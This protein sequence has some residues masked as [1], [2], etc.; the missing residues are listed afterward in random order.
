MNYSKKIDKKWQNIWEE[1]EINKFNFKNIKKKLYCLEMFAY[2]SGKTL[3]LGHWFNFALTDSWARMKKMQGYEVF[4]PMGFDA[5]GLPAENFAI[6]TGIHPQDST[7]ENIKIMKEQLKEM[8]AMFESGSNNVAT[9]EPEYYRWTQWLFLQ[10]YDKKL[11][12]R[13]KAPVNWCENCKTVLANEQ[14]VD[15]MCERC[16]CEIVKK[17]LT[18]WF[19]KITDYAEELLEGLDNLDWPEKTKKN[20]KNWIGKSTG[21]EITLKI[22]KK[23]LYI[24]IFT[25]RIDTLMGVSYC[26]IAPEH[27]LVAK[28]TTTE[29]QNSVNNYIEIALTKGE[30][31][32]IADNG[33]KTGVFTGSYAIHPI[34]KKLIPIWV[35]DYVLEN[36]G[37]GC[38]M[39]VPAHDERD[40]NFAQKYHLP[41]IQVIREIKNQKLPYLSK[42]GVL[43][44]STQTLNGLSVEESVKKIEKI[45]GENV[46]PKINYKLRD[47]LV[48][49]QRY[50]GAPIPVIYCPKCGVVPVSEEDLP[51]LLPYDVEFSPRGESP[52]KNH[53]SFINTK[54]HVCGSEA[55]RDPDTLD[56]FVCS[57]WYFLRYPDFNNSKEIFNTDLINKILPVDKYV[58][59]PEHAIMHLL[60]ARFVT[61][62]LR[63]IGKIDFSE[64]FLSLVHQGLILG[65]DGTKMSKSKGNTISPDGYVKEYGSDVFRLHLMFAFSYADGGSW[66]N[67]GMKAILRFVSRVEN[68]VENIV[69][70]DSISSNLINNMDIMDDSNEDLYHKIHT[71]IKGVT[72]DADKFQFNTV[73]AK[74]M[75]LLNEI[76]NYEKFDNKNEN[77]YAQAVMILIRLLA[78]FAPHFAE[79]M[80]GKLGG[81]YE[82]IFKSNWPKYKEVSKKEVEIVIQVNGKIKYKITL[83]SDLSKEDLCRKVLEKPEINNIIGNKKIKK[84]FAVVNKLVNIV[85]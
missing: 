49:R 50:W 81:E 73:V 2:P 24:T 59:G 67:K 35:A 85:V 83:P 45:L 1:K 56:T 18:Q 44:N 68:C 55:Q 57:S 63:D 15:G 25:T 22:D 58:G 71:T 11:A 6:K 26:V 64:P 46:T 27:E 72:A 28:I 41:I 47:W 60:Y 38:I 79:E 52:L 12:Y 42:S 82:S 17:S 78:P 7:R 74:L 21:H 75:E 39:A 54:C 40:F 33:E 43:I 65:E 76:C 70:K 31:E 29:Y 51:V 53:K 19:F 69:N 36:Y 61:K 32:R 84:V 3:H 16:S 13:K 9:C 30:I 23:D 5:F 62:F 37:T 4:Q 20:Q 34:S 66:N 48:S 8:G 77:L 10:L 80:Y 14:V